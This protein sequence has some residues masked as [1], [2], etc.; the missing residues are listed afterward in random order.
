VKKGSFAVECSICHGAFPLHFYLYLVAIQWIRLLNKISKRDQALNNQ[1]I[2]EG[3]LE[4]NKKN[5]LQVEDMG[6]S[7]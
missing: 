2:K 3:K 6:R 4:V 7:E 5:Y 1:R